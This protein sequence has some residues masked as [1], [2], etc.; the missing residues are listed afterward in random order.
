M[1]ASKT[2]SK[3]MGSFPGSINEGDLVRARTASR[4]SD[5]VPLVETG[6]VIRRTYLAYDAANC[7][8]E[9]LVGN[10]VK[11]FQAKNLFAIPESV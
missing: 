6:T 3:Q 5:G 8:W 2:R 11:E 7:K 4:R 10:D 9:V 1:A